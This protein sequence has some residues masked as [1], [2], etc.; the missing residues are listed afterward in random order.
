MDLLDELASAIISGEAS[1]R[2][3]LM[4]LKVRLCRKHGASRVPTNHEI[5][6]RIPEEL[7]EGVQGVLRNKPVRTMSGVAPVAVMTSPYDC[8]HG[9][10][11]Y[12]PGGVTNNTPQS[13]TGKEPAARRAE[14]HGYDPFRQTKARI[15]QLNAIGHR[16]DKVDL[17]VMGGTFTSRPIEYQ[18]WFV[19]RCFDAMNGV[20][21]PDLAAAHAANETAPARCVGLT[22]ETRPDWLGAEQLEHSLALGA[23]KVEFGVQSLDDGILDGVKRG[24]HVHEVVDATRRAKDAGL[25][26]CYHMMPGLP[27]SD[28]VKDLASFR[29]LFEDERF[30]P[31]MLKIY[32]TLV[33]KGT[34]LYDLWKEG[35]Y[36]PMSLEE[37]TALV[38]DMK[39]AVPEWVRILRV[40]RDIP[41]QLIEAGVRKS[42]LRELALAHLK[43]AGGVCR[44]IRCREIGH[45]P[46]A[47]ELPPESPV[48]MRH[49]EYAASGGR[50]HFVSFELASVDSIVGY[51]RLRIPGGGTDV[52]RV[53]ELHVYGQ[54]APLDGK[55]GKHWQ[56]R[57]F[58][59]RLLAEGER[60][61]S[62]AGFRKVSVTSG[63]GAREYY[64]RL[65]YTA[66]GP[67]MSKLVSR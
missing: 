10:C 22:V 47:K 63:V 27:G 26:V 41:V 60:I 66:D 20:E 61:A 45:V 8:P 50:E 12:C 5:L 18:D 23:T 28:P 59:E 56:H 14:M 38:A 42:H 37:T 25:K 67:Y 51:V 13:Y 24:H 7:R 19:K 21:S 4:R 2:E 48:E 17:I 58:G 34:G 3:E 54:M 11:I 62:E 46:T 49:R 55:A 65:G 6:E 1:T 32:P 16:T 15:D 52:A 9:R 33:V 31:D 53:R 36:T 40:Q 29:S 30:M 43:D 57:G 35:R 39:R 44:C 64:R